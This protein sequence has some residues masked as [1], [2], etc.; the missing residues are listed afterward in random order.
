MLLIAR[1]QSEETEPGS[2][3]LNEAC[4]SL[5]LPSWALPLRTSRTSKSNTMYNMILEG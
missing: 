3:H 4:P 1:G 2:L 5:D